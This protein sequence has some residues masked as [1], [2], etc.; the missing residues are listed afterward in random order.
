MYGMARPKL[1]DLDKKAERLT[2]RFHSGE[3]EELSNQ[4]E[5]A[6][7]CVSELVRRRALEKRISAVTDLKMLSELRRIGGLVK[8][9]FNETNGLYRQKT[10]A[11][12]D[13]LH[14]AAVRIGRRREEE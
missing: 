12:L 13:E 5:V 9:F 8:H 11:L 7:L 3:L 1:N 14:A 10:S 4:A 2:V 6:G